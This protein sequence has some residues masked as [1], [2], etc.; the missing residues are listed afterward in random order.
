MGTS[1]TSAILESMATDALER[2]FT[3]AL[4]YCGVFPIRRANSLLVIPFSF[5][6]SLNLNIIVS[7]KVGGKWYNKQNLLILVCTVFKM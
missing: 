3:M 7:A 5:N 1:R 4:V 2:S 6:I